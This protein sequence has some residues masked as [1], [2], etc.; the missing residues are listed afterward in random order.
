MSENYSEAKRMKK[1]MEYSKAVKIY[2]K[3][4][5]IDSEK[6]LAWEYAYCLKKVDKIEKSIEVCKN[7]YMKHPK[8][9]Y[10]NGLLISLLYLKYFKNIDNKE[11][12]MT[13]IKKMCNIAIFVNS[14]QSDF[15]NTPYEIIM[16]STLK[17]LNK[18]F[19]SFENE[20]YEL[21]NVIKIKYLSDVPGSYI[22]DNKK[23]EYQSNIELYYCLKTKVY[24]Q[25]KLYNECVKVCDEAIVKVNRFHHSNDIWIRMRKYQSIGELGEMTLAIDKMENLLIKINHWNIYYIIGLYYLKIDNKEKAIYNF[26]KSLLSHG[27]EVMKVRVFQIVAVTLNDMNN[28]IWS[29]KHANYAYKIRTENGWKFSNEL[30]GLMD[31]SDKR[32]TKKEFKEFWIASLKDIEGSKTGEVKMIHKNGKFGFIKCEGKDY[33][34]QSSSIVGPNKE[35][36]ELDKVNFTTIKSFDKKKAK[37]TE[38]AVYIT[39]IIK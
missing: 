22:K 7:N 8:F 33:Y 13:K 14:M 21:L 38:E 32:T 24:F 17:V 4:Y 19:A 3:I 16:M 20:I 31:D 6:W 1:N 35:L 37:K 23:S 26:Y 36:H 2:E 10:N 9:E 25:K 15:S 30:K 11:I 18:K 12:T 39:R 28:I 34:F 5:T 27:P 29:A